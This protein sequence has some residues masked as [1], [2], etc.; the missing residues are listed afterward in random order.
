MDM[1]RENDIRKEF[2]QYVHSEE[3]KKLLVEAVNESDINK[4]LNLI[5]LVLCTHVQELKNSKLC[6][7]GL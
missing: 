4:K 6:E 5:V 3:F 2:E 7:E 1:Q